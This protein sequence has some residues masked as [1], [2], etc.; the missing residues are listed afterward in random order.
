MP[1]IQ[2]IKITYHKLYLIE[3]PQQGNKTIKV[4]LSNLHCVFLLH[5]KFVFAFPR[6]EGT[7]RSLSLKLLQQLR[8]RTA[9]IGTATA[10]SKKN[11]SVATG[12]S[13]HEV[14]IF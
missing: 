9:P 10:D 3:I 4:K 11:Q 12:R 8:T 5:I 14:N 1:N 7:G 2:L 13:L 6:Y